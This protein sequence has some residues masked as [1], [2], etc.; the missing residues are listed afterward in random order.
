[1]P[2][3]FYQGK[4]LFKNGRP[5]MSARCCC[6]PQCAVPCCGPCYFP[7][8]QVGN[9]EETL[10]ISGGLSQI[11]SFYQKME[12]DLFGN[13]FIFEW[14]Q[15][16]PSSHATSGFYCDWQTNG[17]RGSQEPCY[18]W[19]ACLW[20]VPLI[21]FVYTNGELNYNSPEIDFR[22]VSYSGG[23]G[24]AGWTTNNPDGSG[25]PFG[26]V[27][28]CSGFFS[29]DFQYADDFFGQNRTLH[30]EFEAIGGKPWPSGFSCATPGGALRYRNRVATVA[31]FPPGFLWPI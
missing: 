21:L 10:W 25:N 12:Y 22:F 30:V 6:G 4:P 19:S 15:T 14:F 17:P 11:I 23:G 13:H 24:N 5:A 8:D 31:D 28:K 16:G 20:S 9:C 27:D 1:V 3:V 29:Y 18:R 7:A 2:P 26:G